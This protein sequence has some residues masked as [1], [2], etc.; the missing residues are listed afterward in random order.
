MFLGRPPLHAPA[1]VGFCGLLLLGGC[2]RAAPRA[3]ETPQAREAADYAAPPSVTSVRLQAGAPV[4]EGA[5]PPGVQVRLGAPAGA[6]MRVTADAQGRWRLR[7]PPADEARIFGLSAR[8]GA[9]QVQGQGYLVVTPGGPA[10][11]LRSG[12]AAV[13]LDAR[14]SP[15]LGAV[16]FDRDGGAVISGLAPPQSLVFLR[17]DGRQTA[18]A[19]TDPA[20]RYAIVL[21][22]PLARGEHSLE[23]AGDNFTNAGAVEVS[24]AQP[25]AAG[26]MRSQFTRGG[27]RIDWLTP[28]GAVQSTVLLD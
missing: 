21:N 24:V 13:R 4:L 3:P 9:R 18:E 15:S 2:G 28:G 12:A 11:L 14:P 6:A 27:L 25:L 20:G 23:V 16:D 10:A 26:P 19:R 5:A 17:L 1:L 22:Q 8:L 7:L